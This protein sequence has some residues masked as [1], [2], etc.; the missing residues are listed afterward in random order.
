MA[1]LPPLTLAGAR[2]L[3]DGAIA[4]GVIGLK[5]GRLTDA[6]LPVVDLSG[7]W[8]LPGVIDLHGDGFERHLSPRPG[9]VF[10]PEGALRLTDRE[11]AVNGITT[12]WAA[13]GWSWEPGWRSPDAAEALLR[14]RAGL[15]LLTDLRVQLRAETHLVAQEE[16]L[17]RAVHDWGVDYVVF[18]DHMDEWTG[19]LAARPTELAARARKLGCAPSELRR[20]ITQ[21]AQDKPRVP[22][23]LCRLA[24][25]FDRL[26]IRY[27]SHDDDS[28]HTRA[29]YSMIGAR[30]CE[31][32]T[33]HAAAAAAQA[34]G[35]PVLMGAPNVVRGRSTGGNVAACDLIEAGLCDVLVSD[36]HF[37]ALVQAAFALADSGLRDLA[38]AWAMIAT[39]P[40]EVMGLTDRGRIAPGLRADLVVINR[41]SRQVEAT[42]AGG[43]LAYLS[44]AAAGR[45]FAAFG[46]GQSQTR[47]AAE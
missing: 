31:F 16:R 14:A 28:G 1:M 25:G 8:V 44:G 7:Y 45:F 15:D 9:V 30:I 38:G 12:A 43:R 5:D 24:A 20:A 34:L 2:I 13:Q 6:A 26:G 47:M 27:G 18:N 10:D 40:A 22:R 42:I 36:Y 19:H 33:A 32:P 3:R 35:D 41:D 4:D 37:P 23:H 39:R 21:A 17:I 11:L 46:A 29:A